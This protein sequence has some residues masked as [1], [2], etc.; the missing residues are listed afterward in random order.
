MKKII[1]LLFLSISFIG[2][3]QDGSKKTK[4]NKENKENKG[5]NKILKFNFTN[6]NPDSIEIPKNLEIGDFYQIQ[7]DSINLNQYHVTLKASDTT[8]SKALEFPTFGKIDLSGLTDLTNT[9]K[10]IFIAK[11][12]EVKDS[13][14]DINPYKNTFKNK[15]IVSNKYFLENI[16]PKYSDSKEDLVKKQTKINKLKEAEFTIDLKIAKDSIDKKEY[17]YMEIRILRKTIKYKPD[18]KINIKKD[19]KDFKELRFALNDVKDS[20]T[21]SI[22]KSKKFVENT[23]G[24]KA[25]LTDSKNISLKEKFTKSQEQL[26]LALKKTNT[27]LEVISSKNIEK[28]I[29][30]IM[31]LYD[32]NK[33]KS[34]P[35]QFTEEEAKVEIFFIPK[36]S[37]SNLQ[38]YSL[39]PVKFPRK[40]NYW[41]LGAS[42]YYSGIK[43]ERVGF[44]TIAINDS[45]TRTKVLKEDPTNGELGTALLL[46]GGKMFNNNFGVHIVVGTGVSISEDILP[47][48]LF[49][50]GLSYG[51]KHSITLDAG[52]NIGNT[53]VISKNT[54]FDKEYI[55]KPDVLI[56]KLDISYFIAVGY[57][58]KI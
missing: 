29:V 52:I 19:L 40:K 26:E 16:S 10:S 27:I 50:L 23:D 24:I 25:F 42:I 53:K 9:F 32:I 35:I 51:K 7:I 45:I 13:L 58:F 22:Q 11:S 31:N 37:T 3:C 46:R 6:S 12:S 36:D 41:S 15:N 56:N 39:F 5:K 28:M 47:R 4:E 17:Q 44:E 18:D 49:G 21:A 2:F 57:T 55:E 34:L 8:Y 33:Y 30:S 54:D 43:S 20:I 38:S 48:A 14:K 1:T